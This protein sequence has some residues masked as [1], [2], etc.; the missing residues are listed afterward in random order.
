MDAFFDRKCCILSVYGAT[1]QIPTGMPMAMNFKFIVYGDS[2]TVAYINHSRRFFIH[3]LFFA[4]SV[5]KLNAVFSAMLTDLHLRRQL[6]LV[7][8]F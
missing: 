3:V 4:L 1:D 8:L 2:T 6:K 7:I 5:R